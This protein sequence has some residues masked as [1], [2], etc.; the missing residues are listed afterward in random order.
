MFWNKIRQKL[1]KTNEIEVKLATR[2]NGYRGEYKQPKKNII[3]VGERMSNPIA[4]VGDLSYNSISIAAR[5]EG[6]YFHPLIE[7]N[8]IASR[9]KG[10]LGVRPK[11]EWIEMYGI[12]AY[13]KWQGQIRDW[14]LKHSQKGVEEQ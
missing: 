9:L 1:I 10:C 13:N 2:K 5:A 4:A 6:W 14:H 8:P 7:C 11:D 3:F 12:E